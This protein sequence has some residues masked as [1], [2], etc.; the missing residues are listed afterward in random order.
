MSVP[1]VDAPRREFVAEAYERLRELIVR[2]QLGPGTRLIETELADRFEMS[3]TP[4][5]TAMYLLQRDGSFDG[6]G[7][8][9][10]PFAFHPNVDPHSGLQAERF[11]D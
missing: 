10:S 1:R 9:A 4:V 3:R 7:G 8:D 6:C 11:A 2:G 5:R